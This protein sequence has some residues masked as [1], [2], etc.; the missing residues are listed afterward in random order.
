[1]RATASALNPFVID[2]SVASTWLLDDEFAPLADDVYALLQVNR[3][4]VPQHWHFEV[5]NALLMAERRSRI[6]AGTIRER[7]NRLSRLSIETDQSPNLDAA[8]DLAREH[9]LSFYDALY[10]ELA[11]RRNMPLA[12]LDNAL[13]RASVMAGLP[14]L[15]Q[16]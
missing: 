1:M 15:S 3:G 5:R 6:V 13:E 7:L 12:T 14:A 2:A 11:I 9:R 10:L 8:L 16:P 4:L